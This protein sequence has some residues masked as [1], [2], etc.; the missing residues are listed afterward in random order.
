MS[1]LKQV[2]KYLIIIPEEHRDEPQPSM[3]FVFQ[4][5]PRLL[6]LLIANYFIFWFNADY[7]STINVI[8]A[9]MYCLFIMLCLSNLG[10]YVLRLLGDVRR[11]ATY[12]EKE[13]L[14]ELFES[15]KERGKAYSPVIDYDLKLYII[16]SVAINA[17]VIGQHTIAVTRGLMAAMNDE[18]IEAIIAHEMGHIINCDGQVS[19]IV[20]LV[21]NVYLWSIIIA[22]KILRLLEN[23]LGSDSFFGSLI[24]F[25]RKIVEI[26]RN[27]VITLLTILVSSTRRK[28]EYKADKKAYEL[29]YGEALL[30][31]LYKLYD[32]EM[33]DKRNLLDKLQSSHP[34]TAFRIEALEE[35][36]ESEE[37]VA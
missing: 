12:K 37:A 21:S 2:L 30:S 4:I 6:L 3:F 22:A 14:T 32:M 10:E 36:L 33:S 13:R 17:C 25:I 9:C 23:L 24:G 5:R 29:G 20:T 27:Y 35:M 16:D 34:K 8:I 7:P 26:G 19:T 15:V 1:E 18:E 31:A 28:E 11:I